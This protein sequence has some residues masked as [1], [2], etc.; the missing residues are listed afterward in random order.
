MKPF[1]F[2]RNKN[3]QVIV[4]LLVIQKKGTYNLRIGLIQFGFG[5]SE[6]GKYSEN[7]RNGS[8]L[9][10]NIYIQNIQIKNEQQPTK[11]TQKK[12]K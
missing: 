12:N 10:E 1:K 5:F 8:A 3:K 2:N 6:S 9:K 4:L 7:T 11:K